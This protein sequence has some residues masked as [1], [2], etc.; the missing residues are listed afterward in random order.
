MNW[1]A[2]DVNLTPATQHAKLDAMCPHCQHPDH[3]AGP[4]PH[5]VETGTCWQRIQIVGGDGDTV[6]SGVVEMATGQEERPC[7]ICR[8]WE[9][10]ETKRVVEHFLARGL[11]A[12]PDGTFTTPIVKDYPGRKSLVL[13]PR[14]FGFCRRDLLP[15]DAQATCENWVPTKRLSEFQDRMGRRR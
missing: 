8:K 10:V 14:N 9:N 2:H 13:D 4:C 5:C 11:V 1:Y 3:G 15:T 7:L 6:A 12:Q